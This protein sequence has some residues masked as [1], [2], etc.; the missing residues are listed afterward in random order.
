M[1]AGVV[2]DRR[3]RITRALTCLALAASIGA[4]GC[5]RRAA[6]P[7]PAPQFRSQALIDSGNAS[8]RGGDYPSAA[9]RYASAAVANPNDPAAF[10][11][12]GMALAKLGRD[13]E[14]RIAYSKARALAAAR[15]DTAIAR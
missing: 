15:A 3:G 10:Y 7:T 12:L 8:Y 13:D 14:A 5:T 9:K 4:A 2:N 11:G 1:E 6:S